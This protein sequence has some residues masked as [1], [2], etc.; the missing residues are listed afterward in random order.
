VEAGSATATLAA[1]SRASMI[2]ATIPITRAMTSSCQMY[3]RSVKFRD[4]PTFLEA[5]G[6]MVKIAETLRSLGD[7]LQLGRSVRNV[8]GDPVVVGGRTVI[9]IAACA[10]A[11]EPAV[12]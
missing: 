6:K 12:E 11:L 2:P 9:P 10:T 7:H 5:P 8:Y 3:A 4:S 1:R